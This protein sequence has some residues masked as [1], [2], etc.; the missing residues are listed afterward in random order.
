MATYAVKWREPDGATFVGRLTLGARVLRL[1]GRQTGADGQA[2][3]RKLR[4]DEL[5]GLRIGRRGAD[6]LDGRPAVIVEQADGRYLV[7]DAGLGAPIVQELVD[8]LAELRRSATW[9]ATVVVSLRKGAIGRARELIAKGPPFDPAETPLV[10]HEVWLTPREV[11][12]VFES[13]SEDEDGLRIPLA[14]LELWSMAAAWSELISGAPRLAEVYA[15]EQ[16]ERPG[17]GLR[18]RKAAASPQ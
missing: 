13:K 2:V 17:A 8:R 7:A 15:A 4:Y 11:V 12:F 18:R 5:E 14:H 10:R 1:D 3:K 16:P 6:R 9:T